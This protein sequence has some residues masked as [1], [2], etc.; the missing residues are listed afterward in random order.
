MA[1]GMIGQMNC[2]DMV[3]YFEVTVEKRPGICSEPSIRFI[4]LVQVQHY[5]GLLLPTVSVNRGGGVRQV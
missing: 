2:S 3:G 4:S 1:R 5:R